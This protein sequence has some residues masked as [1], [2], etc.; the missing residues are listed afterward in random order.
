LQSTAPYRRAT[1]PPT[2]M[3][4][5]EL[6]PGYRL[7]RLRGRGSFGLVWEVETKTGELAA[8]KFLPCIGQQA[9]MEVRSLQLIRDLSHPGLIRVDKVWSAEGCLVI[10]MELADGS[11]ADLLEV[12][13]ADLGSGLPREHLLPLLTQVGEAL[14]YLN[15]R[16]HLLNNQWVT[17]QHCDVTPRNLLV[18]DQT[19]KVSDFGLATALTAHEK[20]H[21]RAGTPAFAGPEVFMGRVS[22]RTDQYALAVCY[23]YLRSGR[24]PFA[25]T[26]PEFDP[27]YVRPYP[28]LDMLDPPEQP[29]ILRALAPAPQDRWPSCGELLAQ[30]ARAG[31]PEALPNLHLDRRRAPRY[32]P[33]GVV[34]CEVLPTL[35]NQPWRAELVDVS[36][37]GVRLRV[38]QPSCPLRPGRLLD[39]AL[40]KAS[41]CLRVPVRLRL[42][43]STEQQ[44]G[45]YDVGGTFDRPLESRHVEALSAPEAN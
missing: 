14:D 17:L 21:P 36:A 25:D 6:H 4:T 23:C 5:P 30:L 33:D 27:M 31:T 1:P 20:S 24:V 28:D 32:R 29:I 9:A 13:Q 15:T 39:L 16:Q 2:V 43:H 18:F 26:P 22:E 45:D 38:F 8:L 42:T 12:Y 19:V 7:R 11:L 34:S 3:I 35:G 40:V 41:E 37:A 10:A 44:G